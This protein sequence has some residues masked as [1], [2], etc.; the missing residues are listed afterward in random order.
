MQ[1]FPD[2]DIGAAK[3]ENWDLAGPGMTVKKRANWVSFIKVSRP[4]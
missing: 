4:W 1:T 2:Y 3:V